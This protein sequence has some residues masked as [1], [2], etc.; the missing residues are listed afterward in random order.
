MGKPVGHPVVIVETILKPARKENMDVIVHQ[1]VSD[2]LYPRTW[3]QQ[4]QGVDPDNEVLFRAEEKL[5][6]LMGR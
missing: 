4:S 1:T 6:L 3:Q 5:G 2:V